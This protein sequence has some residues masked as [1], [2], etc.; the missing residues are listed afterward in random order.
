MTQHLQKNTQ[1]FVDQIHEIQ[2]AEQP[3]LASK[4]L[5]LVGPHRTS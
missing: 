1:I 2:V 5:I 3:R 4:I